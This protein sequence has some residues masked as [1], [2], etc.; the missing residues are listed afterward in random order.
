MRGK[1]N[2]LH[3]LIYP[4]KPKGKY[5]RLNPPDKSV[6]YASWN[7]ATVLDELSPAPGQ[8]LQF[9]TCRTRSDKAV[10][11]LVIGAYEQ[12]YRSGRHTYPATELE[13]YLSNFFYTTP[14]DRIKIILY[15]DAFFASLFR[16]ADNS[17]YPLTSALASRM[18]STDTPCGVIYPSVR[19]NS[20]MN[21][22]V[23]DWVFDQC[24]EVLTT[25]F[26][27]TSKVYGHGIYDIDQHPPTHVFDHHGN[28]SWEPSI[29]IRLPTHS[30][31]SGH[32]FPIDYPSW[33][34]PFKSSTLAD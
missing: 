21:L 6:F 4:Q 32:T 19:A 25:D 28:I 34:V 30:F 1:K 13:G 22:A 5:G 2:N 14:D 12:Y 15:V 24:F 3:D 11:A 29:N 8:T 20:S 23:P 18:F 16:V 33:R 10:I 9:I 27:V 17:M 26:G 7:R 31:Q